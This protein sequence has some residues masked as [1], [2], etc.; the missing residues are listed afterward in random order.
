MLYRRV[1]N[2][3]IG[4]DPN[5]RCVAFQC[6]YW[7]D[8][9]TPL[10]ICRTGLHLHRCNRY[11]CTLAV[12]V[13]DGEFTC[14]VSGY[15]QG[16]AQAHYPTRD[17]KDRFINTC[18]WTPPARRK[19]R[20]RKQRRVIPLHS[21]TIADYIGLIL[22]PRRRDGCRD[23]MLKGCLTRTSF[24]ATMAA[25]ARSFGLHEPS[26]L[27]AADVLLASAVGEYIARVRR[28][29]TKTYT[30][31]TLVAVVLSF[32][33]SGLT[34]RGV[35]VF[36]LIPDVARRAPSAVAYALV[37]GL[38]CRAMSNATRAIRVLFL[39]ARAIPAEL[40]FPDWPGSPNNGGLA[41]QPGV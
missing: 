7:S 39:D 41:N 27:T 16:S 23:R 31:L 1:T 8:G 20:H 11:A 5:H 32:L 33:C 26:K 22:Q 14:P 29:L 9:K 38:Q 15:C 13:E 4:V 35:V 40:I 19:R 3:K 6:T 24:Q 2:N 30:D 36:P 17:H 25:V 34:V 10:F 37:P 12:T 18:T 21:K 28:C